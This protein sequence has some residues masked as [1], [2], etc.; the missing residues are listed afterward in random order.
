MRFRQRSNNLRDVEISLTPLIDL[1]L[2]I[3][4]FFLISTSFSQNKWIQINLPK[5][6]S[7]EVSTENK[8]LAIALDKNNDVFLNKE[9]IS[10]NLLIQTLK[11]QQDK[12][13]PVILA[14]DEVSAHGKVMQILD[15]IKL[16]GLNN[17]SV[18]STE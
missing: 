12:S 9:K 8:I 5:T 2:N 7:G 16:A 15:Q 10:Q 1:F 18:L 4:V 17:I 13:I 6:E 11:D 3:L 14:A